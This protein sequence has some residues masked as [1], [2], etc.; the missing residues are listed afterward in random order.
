MHRFYIFTL[1]ILSLLLVSCT[2]RNAQVE[3]VFA[4]RPIVDK[5]SDSV[6]Y[7]RR[8]KVHTY[9]FLRFYPDGFVIDEPIQLSDSLPLIQA[10]REDVSKWFD[11]DNPTEKHTTGHYQFNEKRLSF[12]TTSVYIEED[13]IDTVI[14]AYSGYN[15]GDSLVLSSLSFKTSYLDTMTYYRLKTF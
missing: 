6:A 7:N 15:Y 3:G 8:H 14:V 12:V 13:P 5:D 1:L 2:R 11:R 4:S 9:E 10:W